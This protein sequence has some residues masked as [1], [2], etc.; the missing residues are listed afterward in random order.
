MNSEDGVD[1]VAQ[2]EGWFK[3]AKPNPTHK[4]ACTQMG[5]H[6]E[7]VAEMATAIRAHNSAEILNEISDLLKSALPQ[8]AENYLNKSDHTDLLDSLCDQIVTAVGVGYM[9]GFDMQGALAEVIRSNN[10]KMVDG[11]F[12]FDANGKIM[13]PDSFSEPNLEPFLNN[14]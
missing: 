14:K 12:I 11:E 2:I 13:K 9:M 1:S 5:C 3:A 7:E 6:F 8:S 10:S 4:D